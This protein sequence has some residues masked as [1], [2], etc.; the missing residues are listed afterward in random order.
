LLIQASEESAHQP[1]DLVAGVFLQKVPTRHQ[2]RALGMREE[3]F[4]AGGECCRVKYLALALQM[5]SV[6]SLVFA[7]SASSHANRPH[8]SAARA[9]VEHADRSP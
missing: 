2:V 4:E 1:A 6:G 3:L 8:L 5:T 7:S 9:P